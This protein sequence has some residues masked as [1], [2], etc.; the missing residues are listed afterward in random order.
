M[1]NGMLLNDF[2][3]NRTRSAIEFP[4]IKKGNAA[5]LRLCLGRKDLVGES[6]DVCLIEQSESREAKSDQNYVMADNRLEIVNLE[7]FDEFEGMF[8]L[9]Q[10]P[11]HLLFVKDH[12]DC[13]FISCLHDFKG[14]KKRKTES[15]F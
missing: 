5:A 2:T 14:Y 1:L 10:L 9:F 3:R 11:H 12:Q 4:A 7:R 13:F 15:L 8:L 6:K